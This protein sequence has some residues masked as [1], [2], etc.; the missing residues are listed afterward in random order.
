MAEDTADT[1]DA[2]APRCIRCTGPDPDP[3]TMHIARLRLHPP[4]TTITITATDSASL[5]ES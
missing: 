1:E 5:P 2:A 3:R 4:T